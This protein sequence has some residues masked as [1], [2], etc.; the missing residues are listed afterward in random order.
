MKI[1]NLD[2]PNLDFK[3]LELIYEIRKQIEIRCALSSELLGIDKARPTSEEV[4]ALLTNHFT[5]W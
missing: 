3:T 2:I 1:E 4:R 5:R